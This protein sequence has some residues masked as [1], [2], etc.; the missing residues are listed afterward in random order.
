MA[1]LSS[2]DT[3]IPKASLFFSKQYLRKATLIGVQQEPL[4][5][6]EIFY[7]I[8]VSLFAS[9]QSHHHSLFSSL[10]KRDSWRCIHLPFIYYHEVVGSLEP[11]LSIS[12]LV[13]SSPRLVLF[14]SLI[15]WLL[16]SSWTLWMRETMIPRV[17]TPSSGLLERTTK[18]TLS[19]T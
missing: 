14:I 19:Q 4:P 5:T 3:Q 2:L 8:C 17:P 18:I 12:I 15:N 6:S 1:L 9:K 11:P 10:W 13:A 7:E 16:A